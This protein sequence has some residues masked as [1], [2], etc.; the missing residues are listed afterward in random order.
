MSRKDRQLVVGG[1]IDSGEAW[2][3]LRAASST[4][5]L[6]IEAFRTMCDCDITLNPFILRGLRG[7][8]SMAAKESDELKSS[9]EYLFLSDD[10]NGV[11]D[12]Q[13]G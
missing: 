13:E 7:I 4:E 9:L 6:V 1:Y 3:L 8:L 2:R 10:N 12:E 11:K 5:R